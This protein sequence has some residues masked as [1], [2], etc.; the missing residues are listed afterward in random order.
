MQL[1]GQ[2]VHQGP[3]NKNDPLIADTYDFKMCNNQQLQLQV[4][5]QPHIYIH[6]NLYQKCWSDPLFSNTM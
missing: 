4:L 5:H 2:N 6:F 1:M 3:V